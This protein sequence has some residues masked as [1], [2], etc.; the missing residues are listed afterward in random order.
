MAVWHAQVGQWGCDRCRR[1]LPPPGPPMYAGHG[2]PPAHGQPGAQVFGQMAPPFAQPGAQ[3]FGPMAPPIGAQ[4]M[5]PACPRC[6]HP[7][8]WYAQAQQFGCDRCQ[9]PL[10]PPGAAANESDI[11][12]VVLKIVLFIVMIGIIVAIKV[13]VRAALR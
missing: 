9:M 4:P 1:M 11:G 10:P 5:P 6:G 3:G 7:A 13:G 8:T 2:A 12:K